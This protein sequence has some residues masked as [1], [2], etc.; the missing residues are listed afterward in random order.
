MS[1][2]EPV[3][4]KLAAAKRAADDARA[5]YEASGY[6]EETGRVWSQAVRRLDALS[7]AMPSRQQPR[8]R[9]R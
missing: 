1:K 6:S 3:Q 4:D 5:A 8:G 9:T 7:V 2:R